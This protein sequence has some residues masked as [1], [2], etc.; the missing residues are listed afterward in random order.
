MSIAKRR[1]L[2]RNS[3]GGVALIVA[4]LALLLI[5]A[6]AAGMITMA[7]TETNISSNF[8]DEQLAFFGARAGVEEARDRFVKG[9]T[10]T[11]YGSLPSTLPGTTNGV[12]YI[13]N[14]LGGETVTPWATTGTHYPD[15]EICLEV[16][17]TS[18]VPGGSPWYTTASASSTY[19]SSP[20]SNWKW[21]RVMEK[22]N[23]SAAGTTRVTSVDG[24]TNGNQICWNGAYETTTCNS[25]NYPVYVITALAVTPSGSRR[26]VEYEVASNALPPIPGAMVFDGSNPIFGAPNSAAFNV[27]GNDADLGPS[28]GVGCGAKTNEPALGG[29]D[30]NAVSTLTTDVSKRVNNYTGLGTTPSIAAESTNMGT[31]NTVDGLTNLVNT[32]TLMA[33]ANVYN[34]TA[35]TNLGTAVPLNPVVNVVNGDV[36]LTGASGAGILVVTG[37][38]T[39]SGAFSYDGIILVIGK[40]NVTQ[41]GA[42]NGTVNGAM[43]VANLYDNSGKLIPTGASPQNPPGVPTINWNGGG[44]ATFQYDSCWINYLI[45]KFPYK[46]LA[47]REL[48][49]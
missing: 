5:T 3:E 18:G 2:S 28:A 39:L 21:I 34:N 33:G 36:T 16:S 9:T 44:N 12:L 6:I 47:E 41:N 15:D 13:T 25:S 20:Q 22:T 19:A 48:M 14:P 29:Y 31:M 26:M 37:N 45:Q 49:Y 30:S 27:N 40:G 17:C 7:G 11:L 42:G 4:L 35:P 43:L 24:L 32:M 23:K 8:K 10:D 1:V 46:V 38:L